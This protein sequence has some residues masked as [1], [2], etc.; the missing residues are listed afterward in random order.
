[1]KKINKI[2][3]LCAVPLSSGVASIVFFMTPMLWTEGKYHLD[4]HDV[5]GFFLFFGL[6]SAGFGFLIGCPVVLLVDWKW[7]RYKFRYVFAVNRPV[8]PGGS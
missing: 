1:M 8:I 7:S 6:I 4:F 5:I 3:R 2:L